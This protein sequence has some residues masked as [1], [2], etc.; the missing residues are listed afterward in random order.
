MLDYGHIIILAAIP[1]VR[2]ARFFLYICG[3]IC[4]VVSF[5][6]P[7]SSLLIIICPSHWLI[8]KIA[9]YIKHDI[10]H[11]Q[12]YVEKYSEVTST[13]SSWAA[14]SIKPPR[15]PCHHLEP[16][17]LEQRPLNRTLQLELVVL[18]VMAFTDMS[19][20]PW[21]TYLNPTSQGSTGLLKVNQ[22]VPHTLP[23]NL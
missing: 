23:L 3:C 21:G 7:V 5:S 22:S 20:A 14:L 11:R 9:L 12:F 1:I 4:L 15:A 13:F 2:H 19:T 6:F 8:I 16:G 17:P 18:C 10:G